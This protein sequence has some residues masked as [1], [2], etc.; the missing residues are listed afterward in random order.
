MMMHESSVV[1]PLLLSRRRGRRQSRVWCGG[2][3]VMMLCRQYVQLLLYPVLVLFLLVQPVLEQP[4]Q[5]DGFLEHAVLSPPVWNHD[6]T[7]PEQR[8]EFIDLFYQLGRSF[9]LSFVPFLPL[10]CFHN[11][12]L[13]VVVIVLAVW[14]LLLLLPR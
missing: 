10:F 4:Y 7:R 2:E 11:D 6:T 9:L 5:A 8:S 1:L 3:Q 12:R 13:V 14:L